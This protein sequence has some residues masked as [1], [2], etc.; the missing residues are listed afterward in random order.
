MS[1]RV[2]C[3]SEGLGRRFLFILIVGLSALLFPLSSPELLKRSS[4]AN[5][6]DFSPAPKAGTAKIG[7]KVIR[8]RQKPKDDKANG[9][10][11]APAEPGTSDHALTSAS[12]EITPTKLPRKKPTPRLAPSWTPIFSKEK[13]VVDGKIVEVEV[14]ITRTP[15]ATAV[16]TAT[17]T[18]KLVVAATGVVGDLQTELS[19]LIDSATKPVKFSQKHL[20][21]LREEFMA[22]ISKDQT[23]GGVVD[24]TRSMQ[25]KI[26]IHR[27]ASVTQGAEIDAELA[28]DVVKVLWPEMSKTAE[29]EVNGAS[30]EI[31][32][33]TGKIENASDELDEDLFADEDD[34]LFADEDYAEEELDDTFYLDPDTGLHVYSDGSPVYAPGEDPNLAPPPP[35][36]YEEPPPEYYEP[37]PQEEYY[38]PQE[39]YTEEEYYDEGYVEEDYDTIEDESYDEDYVEEDYYEDDGEVY[40]DEGEYYE[41]DY[42]EEYYE[43]SYDEYQ[44]ED[45]QEV[46]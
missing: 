40:E 39:G 11:E 4:A 13:Q 28:R 19:K 38:E 18:A 21:K 27:L 45:Y 7:N 24:A 23:L 30:G 44:E 36:V 26:K 5:E 15:T 3:K 22:A 2:I 25:L 46:Y 9:E 37:P 32:S 6:T 33:G 1:N 43:E 17:G 20:A 29:P 31:K 16:S 10:G 42:Q 8:T 14:E 34:E 12:P 41:E 35:P